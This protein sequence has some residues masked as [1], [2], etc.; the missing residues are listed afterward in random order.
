MHNLLKHYIIQVRILWC[1][2]VAIQ[3][4]LVSISIYL[5]TWLIPGIFYKKISTILKLRA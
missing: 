3:K 5:G 1:F 2:F 4:Y